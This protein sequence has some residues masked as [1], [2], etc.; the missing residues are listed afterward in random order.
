[1]FQAQIGKADEARAV[2]VGDTVLTVAIRVT[3]S[4]EIDWRASYGRHRYEQIELPA[5]MSS[6][7]PGLGRIRSG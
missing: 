3:E 5:E 1:L 2:V 7:K 4:D 6:K